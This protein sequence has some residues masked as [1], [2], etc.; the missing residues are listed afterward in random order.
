MYYVGEGVPEDFVRSYA[1]I[2]LASARGDG[3]A[4]RG[5]DIIRK[6][7]TAEQIADA[8]RVSY[9]LCASIPNCAQ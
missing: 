7:M 6:R 4:L 2:T 5:M 8:Q 9:V 3:L 1:W